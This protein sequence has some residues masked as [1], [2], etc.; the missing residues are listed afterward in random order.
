[1]EIKLSSSGG[2]TYSQKVGLNAKQQEEK[3]KKLSQLDIN[4]PILKKVAEAAQKRKEDAAKRRADN[5]KKLAERE[6][7]Q[8]ESST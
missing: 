4:K 5:E 2:L 7:Q 3:L 1:M 8:K 6:A